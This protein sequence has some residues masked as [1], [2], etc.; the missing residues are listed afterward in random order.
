MSGHDDPVAVPPGHPDA[1][2]DDDITLAN[3]LI[4]DL[5]VVCNETTGEDV[6]L[7]LD[8]AGFAFSFADGTRVRIPIPTAHR[9]TL[10]V[11]SLNSD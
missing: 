5:G 4:P 6:P 8:K 3:A 9:L 11:L 2:T 7:L 1:A 10:F